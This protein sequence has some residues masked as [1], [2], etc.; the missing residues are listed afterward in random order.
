MGRPKGPAARRQFTVEFKQ[1]AVR[2]LEASDLPV[3]EVARRLG[4]RREALYQWRQQ[5]GVSTVSGTATPTVS[6]EEE[7]RQLRKRVAELEEE[8]AILGKAMA[9]FAK[10]HG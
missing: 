4:I 8:R 2:Q 5:Y 10:R 9:F 6:V 3:S 7:L 1:E